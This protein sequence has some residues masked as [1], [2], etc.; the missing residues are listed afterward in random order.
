LRCK[1]RY[2]IET[3]PKR[4]QRVMFQTTNPKVKGREVWNKVKASTYNP[5]RVLVLNESNSH[6]ETEEISLYA[7][8]AKINAFAAQHAAALTGDY[9]QEAIKRLIAMDR[10]R[11]KVTWTTTSG[12]A[13]QGPHQTLEEQQAILNGIA[14]EERKKMG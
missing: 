8:E 11:S 7:D 2:W 3:H 13:A 6:I 14:A 10:A 1:A 4:G 5:L 12:E 9:E